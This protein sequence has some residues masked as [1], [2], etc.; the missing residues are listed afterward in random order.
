MK[1]GSMLDSALHIL[2]AEGKEMKFADLWA[3]VKEDLEISPEEEN[4]RIGRFYT[5]LSLSGTF[6]V[7]C[8]NTWDLRVRHTYDK[9]H[10]DVN[11]VYSDVD[12]RDTDAV[13]AAE[14][15]EYNEYVRGDA[16]PIGEDEEQSDEESSDSRPRESAAELLGSQGDNY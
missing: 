11:D 12:E 15:A 9:V 5:D 2:E 6:V 14:E 8:E 16:G 10:I 4:Q 13:D 3:K 7:L 1:E